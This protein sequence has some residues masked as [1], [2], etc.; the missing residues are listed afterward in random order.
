MD[1]IP[2]DER[3]A[4]WHLVGSDERR[5]SGG[6]ATVELLL[7]LPRLAWLGRV[8][9]ALRLTWLVGVLYHAV[10][11]QR[12]KLSRFFSDAPGPKRFP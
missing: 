5:V 11:A 10:A 9:Q 12:G 1:A 6:R 2:A 3:E 4:S 7:L 8:I